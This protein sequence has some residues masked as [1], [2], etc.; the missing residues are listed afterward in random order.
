MP[1]PESPVMVLHEIRYTD[2]CRPGN[3]HF[4]MHRVRMFPVSDAYLERRLPLVMGENINP[5]VI[6]D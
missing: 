5:S 3:T 6:A 1:D 2:R 4:T